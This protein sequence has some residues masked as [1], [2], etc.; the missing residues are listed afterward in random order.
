MTP[1]PESTTTSVAERE[2]RV[3]VHPSQGRAAPEVTTEVVTVTAARFLLEEAVMNTVMAEGT[4]FEGCNKF[5]VS[6]DWRYL[7]TGDNLPNM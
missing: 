3:M 6:T 4:G 1:M 5:A 2:A 7:F